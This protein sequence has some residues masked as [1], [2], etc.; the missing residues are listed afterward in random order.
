M[1]YKAD[2]VTMQVIRYGLEAVA[3]DMG[4]NLMRMGRTTIVKEIMD[5]NCGVL[6]ADG[7][8]L[9]QAHL[10]PLMMFSLPTSAKNMLQRI[11]SFEEGDV[12]ISNDPYLGGQHLLDVQFFSPVIVKGERIGFVANIAHQLDMGGAVPGGVAGGLTEIYQEGLRIPFVK[13]YRAGQEDRQIFDLISS[14]IRI[15]EK[16]IEDFRAQAATTM[17]GVK[18]VKAL[19]MKYGLDVFRECTRMLVEYS[20]KRVRHFI[21]GL[22]DGDYIGVDYLDDDGQVDGPVRVQVNVHISGG[23]MKVDFEGSSPQAKG[24]VN[25]PWACSQG[26][27]FYTMVGIIDPHMPLN[28]GTFKPIEVTSKQGLVTNPLPPAGVTA[29]SQTMTKIVEAMLR[30]MSEVVP[31]RVVAGS[32]GQACTNSFSGID[33]RT[34]KHFTYVE[35]QGGGAGARPNKDGPDG[36]DLHLGRFMNTPIEAAELEYPVMIER[37]GF[38]PDSGGAGKFRGGLSLRRDIRFLSDVIWARYSDRQKFRPKGLFGGKEGSVGSLILNPDTPREKRCRSKGV[39]YL[40]EGDL[41]SIRLPGSGGYGPPWKRD[42]S[43]VIDDVRNGKV[44]RK[45]ALED[46]LVVLTDDFALDSEETRKLRRSK[47]I[48]LSRQKL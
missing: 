1:K 36:Q 11:E 27:V 16:T 47:G 40:K 8:I 19:V 33:P 2:P 12:I 24:N 17:V 39:D 28:D 41:L 29:R 46:Y 9:A 22:P 4:Y 23:T 48:S 37:Y 3:D 25:C 20:E 26:G 14:N 42:I 7:G 13:L 15:P 21:E 18:R 34:G 44:S 31:D 6:N 10:C 45:S 5:I 32:H 38:I 30:A 35:I 43:R